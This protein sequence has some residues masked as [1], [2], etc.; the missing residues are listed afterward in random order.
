MVRVLILTA[1][2]VAGGMA[3]WLSTGTS[4]STRVLKGKDDP[5]Y[6]EVLVAIDDIRAGDELNTRKMQWKRWPTEAISPDLISKTENAEAA[7][8]L[9][10]TVAKANFL[11]G[12]PIRKEKLMSTG[13]GVM[14]MT[15]EPGKRA[16]AV[17]VSAGNTAGGFILPNDRVDVIHT[18]YSGQKNQNRTAS[19]T[20]LSN[21]RILA[22]DQ[23]ADGIDRA[24]SVVGKTAT[25]ELSPEQVEVITSAE[26][27]GLIS[28]AL[29]AHADDTEYSTMHTGSLSRNKMNT[30]RVFKSGKLENVTVNYEIGE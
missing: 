3:A 4:H 12:E 1:A 27:S 22:I 9:K 29:R 25:L 23:S 15:I 16:I 7:D 2:V 8:E 11:A 13:S 14:S 19:R 5:V 17:K 21:V 6:E 26:A 20:I 10:G 24:T 18:R 28:L 30:V